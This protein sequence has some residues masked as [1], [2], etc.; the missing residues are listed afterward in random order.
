MHKQ[1]RRD[2]NHTIGCY[3]DRA[4]PERRDDLD[5]TEHACLVVHHLAYSRFHLIPRKRLLAVRC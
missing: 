4:R 2:S 5:D 3:I 1:H